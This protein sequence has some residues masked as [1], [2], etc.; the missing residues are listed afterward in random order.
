MNIKGLQRR[1]LAVVLFLACTSSVA[2][3]HVFVPAGCPTGKDQRG[4]RSAIVRLVNGKLVLTGGSG[5][6][7]DDSLHLS[8]CFDEGLPTEKTWGSSK[9][10]LSSSSTSGTGKVKVPSGMSKV[11]WVIAFDKDGEWTWGTDGWVNF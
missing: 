7:G 3:A 10:T 6:Q 4:D 8:W 5:T 2:W 1:H 11:H 9:A